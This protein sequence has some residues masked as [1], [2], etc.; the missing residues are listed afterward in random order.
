MF[1]FL[2]S[3][4][5]PK[6]V[7]RTPATDNYEVDNLIS[8]KYIDKIRGFISYSAIKPPVEVEFEF[9]CPV[10]IHYII[11]NTT[12]GNQKCSG[13]ELLAKKQNSD[14]ISIG[15]CIYENS[16]IVFCNSRK[17]SN[18]QL[19]PNCDTSFHLAF[20]KSH[21]FQHF[22]NAQSIKIIIFRTEKSV[23]CIGSVE[24][25]GI[26]SKSCSKLTVNTI[27]KLATGSKK[28]ISG[29]TSES[30]SEEFKIPEDF[31]DDLTYELMT[32]P[33]TLPSGKTIDQSTLEK[34]IESE[35]SFGRK[36]CDPFTGIK[37]NETLKPV[38]NVGLKSRIDMFVLQNSHRSE[39][40]NHKR[41][42]GGTSNNDFINTKKRTYCSDDSDL[43]KAL[44]E[45]KRNANFKTFTYDEKE[46]NTCIMCKSLFSFLYK[47]PCDHFYCRQCL[48][49]VSR[50]LECVIC[51]KAFST[52]DVKKCY[53]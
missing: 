47:I 7:C 3:K 10:N 26:P 11:I 49:T 50:N 39:L 53:F 38:I 22:L 8:N 48:L 46:T 14:Y 36:P 6:V 35:K 15:K 40:F 43:E 37:F 20:F 44:S 19:P 9:I 5:V 52:K 16:G 12:V 25:W 24:V 42:L 30:N 18:T 29:S 17:Y 1:N 51:K 32:I 33:M 27:G 13:I 34:Q 28:E 2:D 4:L 23:P 45:A 21:T 31:K 41:I